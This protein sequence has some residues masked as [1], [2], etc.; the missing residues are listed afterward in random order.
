[1]GQIL[2]VQ[3][4]D[5]L[6]QVWVKLEEV[7]RDLGRVIS[8]EGRLEAQTAARVARDTPP[9]SSYETDYLALAQKIYTCRI[10]I[11]S[12]PYGLSVFG[13]PAWNVM[14][15]LF[16][17]H[18]LGKVVCVKHTAV[19]GNIPVPTAIRWLSTL[20]KLSLVERR[21]D[22][23]DR[24]RTFVSLS[25]KGVRIMQEILGELRKVL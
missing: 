5:Q 20:E 24:R 1:M 9:A 18:L 19:A 11:E 14:L 22:V 8:A 21:R 15:D 3:L 2:D 4:D 25:Q 6:L 16:I 23:I 12:S 17:A 13:D 10:K 7:T